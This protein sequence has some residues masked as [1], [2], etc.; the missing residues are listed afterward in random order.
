[1][2]M[3]GITKHIQHLIQ[4]QI[5]NPNHILSVLNYKSQDLKKN[6]CYRHNEIVIEFKLSLKMQCNLGAESLKLHNMN[7][8]T[9]KQIHI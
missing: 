2:H 3:S 9:T 1:M 4:C 8:N 6:F 5:T 7:F